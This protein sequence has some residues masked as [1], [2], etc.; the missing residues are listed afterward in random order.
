MNRFHKNAI[1]IDKPF[2]TDIKVVF[3]ED[4]YIQK[5][6]VVKTEL[7]SNTIVDVDM[8]NLQENVIALNKLNYF[9]GNHLH[10]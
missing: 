4:V 7:Q 10:I 6:L 1:Y 8:K 2:S 5:A 3:K 9:S